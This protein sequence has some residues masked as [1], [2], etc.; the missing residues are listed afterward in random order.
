MR[1]TTIGIAMLLFAAFAPPQVPEGDLLSDEELIRFKPDGI[2]EYRV[3]FYQAPPFYK[4]SLP[5]KYVVGKRQIGSMAALVITYWHDYGGFRNTFSSRARTAIPGI[6]A[7]IPGSAR[8]TSPA[9]LLL[10]EAFVTRVIYGEGFET[11]EIHY[12]SDGHTP[13][14]R[15]RSFI[16][17]NGF[18][19]RETI[20]EGK[21]RG[22]DFYF[23]WPTGH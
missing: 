19:S 18:K 8:T 14:F 3:T 13:I 17:F 2:A 23:L 16:G 22:G 1:S 9:G 5:L 10:A 7:E 15:G 6:G 20:L 21:K 12:A 4:G 11:E